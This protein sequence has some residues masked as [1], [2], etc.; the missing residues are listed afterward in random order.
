MISSDLK[1]YVRQKLFD[2]LT[3]TSFPFNSKLKPVYVFEF[4][5]NILFPVFGCNFFELLVELYPFQSPEENLKASEFLKQYLIL[6]PEYGM[7]SLNDEWYYPK[8][9]KKTLE[10]F[11]KY[12]GNI[13]EIDLLSF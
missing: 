4:K 7:F 11:W 10:I 9:G 5:E 1:F 12:F 13:L 3:D 6:D 8:Y 2:S